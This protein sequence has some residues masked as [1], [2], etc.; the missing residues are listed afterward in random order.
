ME[1]KLH[2]P[3]KLERAILSLMLLNDE[4]I[5]LAKK[6]LRPDYF[7]DDRHKIICRAIFRVYFNV[8]K[9]DLLLVE[10]ELSRSGLIDKAGGMAYLIDLQQDIPS[11]GMIDAYIATLMSYQD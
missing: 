8:G 9:V 3:E 11:L 1:N 4:N 7:R 6:A 10:D 2:T 5:L